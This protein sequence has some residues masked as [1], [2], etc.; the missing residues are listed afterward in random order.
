MEWVEFSKQNN[1]N[2]IELFNFQF[3]LH[4]VSHTSIHIKYNKLN[5]SWKLN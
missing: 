3:L 2:K 1:N 4:T 5:N